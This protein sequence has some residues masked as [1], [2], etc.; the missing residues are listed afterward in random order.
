MKTRQDD[1]SNNSHAEENNVALSVTFK[2]ADGGYYRAELDMS[3]AS[4]I[5]VIKGNAV[6][7][8]Q[9]QKY[10]KHSTDEEKKQYNGRAGHYEPAKNVIQM[11]ASLVEE[12]AIKA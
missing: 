8:V 5:R 4:F 12:D 1:F 9:F 7:P 3:P 6:R 2:G 10:V 11:I